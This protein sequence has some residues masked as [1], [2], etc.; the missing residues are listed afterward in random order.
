MCGHSVYRSNIDLVACLSL[1]LFY[2]G[3]FLTS[4]PLAQFKTHCLWKDVK[5]FTCLSEV[6]RLL[7]WQLYLTLNLSGWFEKELRAIFVLRYLRKRWRFQNRNTFNLF[8]TGAQTFPHANCLELRRADLPKAWILF[9]AH[10]L[11][12]SLLKRKCSNVALNECSCVHV[13]VC[14][15]S[16]YS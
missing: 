7:D 13:N 11:L 12:I 14:L 16:L 2:S 6:C 1:F 10:F 3:S 4:C 15:F 8:D 5:T 9:V